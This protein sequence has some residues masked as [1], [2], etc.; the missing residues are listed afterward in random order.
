MR[1]GDSEALAREKGIEAASEYTGYLINVTGVASAA[2][3]IPKY[4][5][6]I[7]TGIGTGRRSSRCIYY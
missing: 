1:N 4:G 7:A 5:S 3:K 6:H 2:S